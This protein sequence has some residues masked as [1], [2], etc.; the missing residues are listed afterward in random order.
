MNLRQL[1][2]LVV[3]A[4]EGSF[5]KAAARVHLTQSALSRS[6]QSLE[7]ALGMPLCD[8]QSRGI[9]LTPGGRLVLERARKA[10]FEL[11]GLECDVRLFNNYELGDLSFGIGPFPAAVLLTDTLARLNGTHRGLRISA[12][13]EDWRTLL[14]GLR[15][16]RVDFLVSTSQA[17]PE[18]PD[19]ALRMLPPMPCGWFARS[20]H[21]ILEQARPPIS[22]LHDLALAGVPI[23]DDARE[24]L[25]R[26]MQLGAAE[27]VSFSVECNS[28]QVLR[29]LA[30]K[31]D[32]ILCAPVSSVRDELR[33][34]RLQ[35][36]HFEDTADFTTQFVIA[37]LAHRTLTPI[38]QKAIDMLVE[39]NL[40]A[41]EETGS[42]SGGG[43]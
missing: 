22:M 10:L 40:A 33:E 8:R 15:K 12:Q 26:I 38:A 1:E 23:P 32:V 42:F 29:E 7:E 37:H 4:E 21:P 18:S 35:R 39:C 6:I 31:S 20:G 14:E 43:A 19:L 2:H 16:E 3:L 5:V 41:I 36:I 24:S 9:I 34:G 27:N 25:R 11:R 17:I 28:F 13:V 30:G